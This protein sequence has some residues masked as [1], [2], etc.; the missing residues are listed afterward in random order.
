MD[1]MN[2]IHNHNIEIL[3]RT[4]PNNNFSLIL[5]KYIPNTAHQK[6]YF[7]PQVWNIWAP[8]GQKAQKP[9]IAVLD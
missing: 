5:L 3:R 7:N 6:F 9:S 8:I 4:I 1:S 2:S